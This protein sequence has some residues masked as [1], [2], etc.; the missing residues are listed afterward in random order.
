MARDAAQYPPVTRVFSGPRTSS[1]RFDSNNSTSPTPPPHPDDCVAAQCAHVRPLPS[2]ANTVAIG[3]SVAC[4]V[5]VDTGIDVAPLSPGAIAKGLTQTA[6]EWGGEWV[7]G[8]G[9]GGGL[10]P[11]LRSSCER[12][13]CTETVGFSCRCW[14]R[15]SVLCERLLPIQGHSV[16]PRTNLHRRLL[17]AQHCPRHRDQPRTAAGG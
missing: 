17:R 5:G 4:C 14:R 3:G 1:W 16:D 10:G 12:N 13:N 7:G 15:H 8:G 2:D 11:W 6:C 9:G